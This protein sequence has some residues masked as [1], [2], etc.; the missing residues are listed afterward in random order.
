MR[1]TS[2]RD[3]FTTISVPSIQCEQLWSLLPA[4]VM[5]TRSA[6]GATSAPSHGS[7]VARTRLRP[8][9]I[10]IDIEE[11]HYVCVEAL[12]QVPQALLCVTNLMPLLDTVTSH[13]S[14]ATYPSF[15]NFRCRM[16]VTTHT[17][18]PFQAHKNH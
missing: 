11:R 3:W 12:R 18:S 5:S 17:H 15:H 1:T 13:T 8:T 10:K 4:T 16:T 6:A 7:A 9:W 2:F 14:I